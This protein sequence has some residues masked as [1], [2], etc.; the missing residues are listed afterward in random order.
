MK[1]LNR[2]HGVL[3][4]GA[5]MF[6]AT[7]HADPL[8]D[9]NKSF[10]QGAYAQALARV[11]KILEDKPKDAPA[12]FLKGIILT[13]MGNSDEAIKV[14]TSLNEDYP[15]LPEPYNNLA[16]LYAGQGK[17]EKAKN[18]LEMAIQ[19]HPTYVTA[20]ENLG[21]I[22]AKLASQSYDRALQLDHSNTATK[23]KLATIQ[24]LFQETHKAPSGRNTQLASAPNRGAAE[25][26]RP[27]APIVEGIPVTGSDLVG[28]ESMSNVVVAPVVAS[29]VVAAPIASDVAAAPIGSEVA[30]APTLNAADAEKAA[31]KARINEV[32]GYVNAWVSAWENKHLKKYIASYTAD[33]HPS[34]KGATHAKWADQ[35][36]SDIEDSKN[37]QISISRATVGFSDATHATVKFQ[38]SLK[39]GKMRKAK[40]SRKTLSMVK[41]GGKWLIAEE[42]VK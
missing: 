24:T 16:V 9:A 36:R 26:V 22:Y 7:L 42:K 25:P 6:S 32:M 12:R 8:Q 29:D 17:Y 1:M 21:D 20:H 35:R 3:L 31:Q 30:A 28:K 41:T 5:L 27:P 33:F 34:Q 13:E 14:F 15:E 2:L 18:A 10:K 19:T 39:F 11:E 38:Q 40:L 37:I 23:A 4:C